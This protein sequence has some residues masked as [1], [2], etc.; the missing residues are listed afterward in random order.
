MRVGL[1]WVKN[2]DWGDCGKR[3]RGGGRVC[4]LLGIRMRLFWFIFIPFM[5][6]VLVRCRLVRGIRYFRRGF[7]LVHSF[8]SAPPVVAILVPLFVFVGLEQWS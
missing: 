3:I 4:E 2:L 8:R 1:G 7:S 6:L 5:L